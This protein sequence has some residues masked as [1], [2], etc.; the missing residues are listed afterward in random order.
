MVYNNCLCFQS[1]SKIEH[2]GPCSWEN[3]AIIQL[4]NDQAD[5]QLVF[6]D[7]LLQNALPVVQPGAFVLGMDAPFAF[8]MPFGPMVA[9]NDFQ[10]G[11][12]NQGVG[13]A[14]GGNQA[15]NAI[16]EAG[17]ANVAVGN[18]NQGIGDANV[19]AGD[20]NQGM[21][22]ANVAAGDANQEDGDGLAYPLGRARGP[23]RDHGRQRRARGHGGQRRAGHRGR[24]GRARGH[25]KRRAGDRGRQ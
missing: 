15:A 1:G 5:I 20:A 9:N 11:V 3:N 12:E 7:A 4:P 22:D 14:L 18:A 16:H 25:G 23:N 10:I 8:A 13:P 6:N 2:G 21:G 24:Q 19:A 17:D